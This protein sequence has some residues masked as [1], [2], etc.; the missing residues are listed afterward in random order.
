MTEQKAKKYRLHIHISRV[1]SRGVSRRYQK[2][3]PDAKGTGHGLSMVVPFAV[4]QVTDPFARRSSARLLVFFR[5]LIFWACLSMCPVVA[6]VECLVFVGFIGRTMHGHSPLSSTTM[7]S[8]QARSHTQ[9]TDYR[10][11]HSGE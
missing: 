5:F 1:Q 8:T 2:P 3:P 9:R 11:C 10:W 4:E 7:M 6:A